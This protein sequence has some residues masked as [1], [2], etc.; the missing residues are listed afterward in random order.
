MLVGKTGHGPS[1]RQDEI[2]DLMVRLAKSGRRVVR[3]KGGDPHDLRPRRRRDRRVSRNAGIAIEVVPGI[4]AAQG[5]ASRLGISLTQRK[6]ARRL[7]YITG[8]G[9]DG[10][11]PDDIDWRSLA[12]PDRHHRGL[13]A[14]EDARRTRRTVPWRQVSIRRRPLSPSRAPRGP[15]RRYWRQRSPS[16][17]TRIAAAALPGPLLVM[18]GRV[19]ADLMAKHTEPAGKLNSAI[20]LANGKQTGGYNISGIEVISGTEVHSSSS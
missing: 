8:H 20:L 12:D 10:R 6:D 1:C 9:A 3:L 5:A 17:P 18:F 11:L 4:T 13:H 16:C 2:N 14:G 19:F 7:Q 15:A